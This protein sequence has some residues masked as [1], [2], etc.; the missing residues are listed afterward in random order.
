MLDPETL[1]DSSLWLWLAD[2]QVWIGPVVCAI[3]FVESFAIAGVVV[4]G[5]ALLA[6]TAFA[7]GSTGTELGATLAW[8]FA[9]AV[10][11]DGTSYLL[12]R[13]LG[14]TV[15]ERRPLRSHPEWI[16]QGEAFFRRHGVLGVVLGRFVGP[17]RPVMPLIAGTLRMPAPRFF[18]VNLLSA[19]GWAPAY[20]LPGY[21]VGASMTEAVATP[22]H[23]LP[24]LVVAAAALWAL[25]QGAG[26][27]WRSGAR[28][29]ALA[30]RL[31]GGPVGAWWLRPLTPTAGS[32][33]RLSLLAATATLLAGVALL[34]VMLATVP[35]LEAWR[36]FAA[37]LLRI[38]GRLS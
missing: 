27:A 16:E 37:D 4:P 36:A 30:R 9:G 12:G 22:P 13:F 28:D 32:D 5:V 24:G 6:I 8:A 38:V 7:A 23:L 19:L 2:R 20:V 33:T 34:A 21:L 3:A 25:F 10:A 15:R 17:I 29:G 35:A 1:R 31:E 11:G 18:T 14:P 26:T